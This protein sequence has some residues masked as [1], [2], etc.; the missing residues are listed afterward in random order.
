MFTK[1]HTSYQRN[2][3]AVNVVSGRLLPVVFEVLIKLIVIPFFWGR[4]FL[5]QHVC[6]VSVLNRLCSSIGCHWSSVSSP[7]AMPTQVTIS[8]SDHCVLC[9]SVLCNNS[10][11]SL[12]ATHVLKI[13]K[14][15]YHYE[16][17][18]MG[19]NSCFHFRSR[20]TCGHS[21]TV[22]K[23]RCVLQYL[24]KGTHNKLG[25]KN[26]CLNIKYI[27]IKDVQKNQEFTKQIF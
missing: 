1:F 26:P 20:H 23:T 12:K 25:N 8:S 10:H 14:H 22:V 15:R 24:W 13:M 17:R 11:V 16:W 5:A 18:R 6:C 7:A 21:D 9:T 3:W 2:T 4:Q 27:C 19:S